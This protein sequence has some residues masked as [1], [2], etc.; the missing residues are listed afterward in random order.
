MGHRVRLFLPDT[1]RR[2]AEGHGPEARRRDDP[3]HAGRRD[4]RLGELGVGDPPLDGL[5]ERG[6]AEHLE[7]HPE[8]ERAKAARQLNAEVGEVH[9]PFL[10]LRPVDVAQVVGPRAEDLRQEPPVA[11]EHA[12]DLEGLEEPL[13]R[14][15]RERVRALDP[16]QREPAPVAEESAAAVGGVGMEPEPLGRAELRELR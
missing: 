4:P 9:L 11:H 12:S 15:E 13:V 7:R 10:V 1:A 5:P 3:P 8:L 16:R 14:I 2:P 6:Q